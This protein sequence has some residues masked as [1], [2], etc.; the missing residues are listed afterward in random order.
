MPVDTIFYLFVNQHG[1]RQVL[2]QQKMASIQRNFRS[3]YINDTDPEVSEDLSIQW[4][5]CF[6]PAS[7][8]WGV[9]IPHPIRY[10]PRT[11]A[12]LCRVSHRVH[13]RCG[14]VCRKAKASLPLLSGCC[15]QAR[16]HAMESGFR[17]RWGVSVAPSSGSQELKGHTD[18]RNFS[19]PALSKAGR[20]GIHDSGCDSRS[21]LLSFLEQRAAVRWGQGVKSTTYLW[22]ERKRRNKEELLTNCAMNSKQATQGV[23]NS[24]LSCPQ[25]CPSWFQPRAWANLCP[26][27]PSQFPS[28]GWA[29]WKICLLFR[30]EYTLTLKAK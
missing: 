29:P 5:S 27:F 4:L 28:H 12:L 20:W 9:L 7:M 17:R 8:F 2:F 16:L 3:L 22:T 10:G 30:F 26:R 19:P 11:K 15:L 6:T 24:Y 14:Q 23:F 18:E 13:P 1:E 25:L 21:G